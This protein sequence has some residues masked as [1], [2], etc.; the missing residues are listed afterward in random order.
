MTLPPPD[1]QSIR[2]AIAREESRLLRLEEERTEAQARLLSLEAALAAQS[3]STEISLSGNSGLSASSTAVEKIALF[4]SRL[5]GREDVYPRFCSNA[6]TGRQGY[7]PACGN[8]WVRGVCEKPRVKCGECPN[9]AFLPVEDQVI[10]DHLQGRHVVGVY[11]LLTDERCWFLAADFDKT[12]W[13]DD[14]AA[15]VETCRVAGLP[16]AVERSRSGNG[17]HVWF[18]FSAPVPA[19]TARKMGCYLITETMSRR[20][21]LSMESYDRLFPNQDTLP[22]GGFGNLIALPLQHGPRQRGNTVFVDDQ[23]VPHPDQWKFLS[24]HPRVEPAT[25]DSV[26]REATRKGLVVGARLSDT[27][28]TDSSEPWTRLPS[29]QPRVRL[30]APL[31]REVR[32]VMAQR[33]FVAKA[34]LAPTHLNQIKRLAAFQNPEFYKKQSLRLSTAL[35]PRVVACA[36]ELAEHVALPRGC[37]AELEQLLRGHDSALLL[38]DQ[39]CDGKPLD[40]TFQGQLTPVQKKAGR[41]LLRDDIG[42]LVAP[43]GVGKT[44][45]GTYL[46]AARSRS[47]LVLVHRQPLLDQWV[48][49]LSM[50][51]GLAP[52]AIGQIGA[53]KHAPTGR[54]DVAMIQSL[55]RLGG[56]DDLVATYGHVIVDECHHIPA[57]SFERVLS[58]VKARFVTGLT[59]TPRRRD[60]LHPITEMQLGPVRF[61]VDARSQAARRPFDHRLIIRESAFTR[62]R[63]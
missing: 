1:Q 23:F 24:E 40:V 20:H 19:T 56:V 59:A 15:F 53:G 62:D 17:A 33:L 49:Q 39:R 32:A 60:G 58:E 47:T 50:F 16:G 8:E 36:E 46:I 35:T 18:F 31:P 52:K 7:A 63:M 54:L 41:A 9:Q 45:I 5:R 61:S 21:Q 11:P 43:P 25:V 48:A 4:R 34:G 51:L 57:A 12:S 37:V 55:V 10:L 27:T 14:V 30:S 2:D 38:E 42:V 3:D 13:T 28:D 29:G 6:R 26:A 22:R 44:V